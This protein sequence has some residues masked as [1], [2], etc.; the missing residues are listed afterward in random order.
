MSTDQIL[1]GVGLIL[2]LA[3]GSQVLATR[4]P[5]A[6]IGWM[7]PRGIVAAATATTFAATLAAHHA[8]GASKIL[9]VTFLVIV[10]TVA[11]YGLTAVPVAHR[12]GVT[13]PARTRPLLIGGD[14]WVIDLARAFRAAA[15]PYRIVVPPRSLIVKPSSACLS[16]TS[17]SS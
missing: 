8:G 13:R 11:L 3:V 12:L 9:P 5:V 6:F 10:A 14:P 17:M 15:L 4:P 2:V 1:F 16:A 7:A